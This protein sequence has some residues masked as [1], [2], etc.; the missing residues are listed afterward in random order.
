MTG[1][2]VEYFGGQSFFV[3]HSLNSEAVLSPRDYEC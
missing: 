1:V 3:G 2:K